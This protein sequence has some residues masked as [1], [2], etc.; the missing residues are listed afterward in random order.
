MRTPMLWPATL[1][2][3]AVWCLAAIV[4]L[5]TGFPAGWV[6]QLALAIVAVYGIGLA[7]ARSL[8]G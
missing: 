5:W 2:L 6:A 3:S 1:G 8:R 7:L 4:T